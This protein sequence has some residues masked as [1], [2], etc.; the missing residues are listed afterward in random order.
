MTFPIR[1]IHTGLTL[2]DDGTFTYSGEIGDNPNVDPEKDVDLFK[3]DLGVGDRLRLPK[4]ID[5][6]DEND[7]NIGDA[8]LKMFD[9]SKLLELYD[10][11]D[12]NYI[13]YQANQ[14]GTFYVGISGDGN[15]NYNFEQE[16]SG[17]PGT[18]GKY[19][20]TIETIGRQIG[21]AKGKLY[22]SSGNTEDLYT[23]NRKTG[24]ATRLL[25]T[26]PNFQW[27]G[28]APSESSNFIYGGN[29]HLSKINADGS[30]AN[31]ISDDY[32]SNYDGLAYDSSKN[33]LYGTNG[34]DFYRINPNTGEP[35]SNLSSP[36]SSLHGL[37]FGNEGVYGLGSNKDLMFYNPNTDDW[38]VI[39]DT[40]ISEWNNV[41][42]AFDTEKNVLYAKR[43]GDTLLYEID[44]S[45]A[46]VTVLGDTGIEDGGGLA[47]INEDFYKE[48]NDT[49]QRATQTGLTK[50]N[51]GIFS[52]VGEIGD[53]TNILPQNDVDLFEIHLDLGERVRLPRVIQLI[54][55]EGEPIMNAEVQLFDATGNLHSLNSWPGSPGS[56]EYHS[57]IVTEEDQAG[58]FYVG[59]SGPG[60]TNYN[61]NIEGSGSG[62][63]YDE[64]RSYG[65]TI[66]TIGRE[67]GGTGTRKAQLYFSSD[68]EGFYTLNTTTGN[69]TPFSNDNYL[70]GNSGLAPSDSSGFLYGSNNYE[71]LKINTNGSVANPFSSYGGYEGL[72]YDDSRNILYGTNGYD[73]YSINPKTGEPISYLGSPGSLDG[74][75]FG[76]EGV[77]GLGSSADLMFYNPKTNYWSV[78]GYTGISEWNNVGLAFDTEQNVL[79]AKRDGDTLLYEIDASTGQ[80]Q[81]IGD[82]GIAD[83]GGLALVDHVSKGKLYFSSDYYGDGLYTLNTTTG[84]ATPV[85]INGN[86]MWMRGLAPSESSS[87]IYGSNESLFKINADG[88]VANQISNNP[89]YYNGLAYDS[90]RNILYGTDGYNL[91]T[92]NPNTGEPI[93]YLGSPGSLDGLAF[94]NEGV[95]GLG[96]SEDLMFY[97]PN[98]DDWSIIGK[99]GI[100]QWQ[101]VGL[102]FDT[103]KNVLYAKRDGDTLL[104][105]IDVSTAVVTVLG[106]TGIEYGGGLA[107]VNEDFYEEP[108]DTIARATQTGLTQKNHGI[109]SY[110]GEI[111]DNTNL[112]QPNDVDLFEI[113]LDLGEI[114]RLPT[115]IQLIGE[116]GEPIGA[117]E[118]QL[119]DATGGSYSL[120]PWPDSPDYQ[121]FIVTEEYQAGSFYVG[122]SGPGN[123]NYDP[124]IEGSG[125]GYEAGSYGLTIETIGRQ[126]GQIESERLFA[127]KDD[128]SNQIVELN[129]ETGEEINNFLAPETFSSES[130]GLAFDG[131]SLFFVENN[132]YSTKLWELNPDTGAVRDSD[133]ISDYGV[134]E[135]LAVLEGKV[136]ILDYGDGDILEFDPVIDEVTR[137]LDIDGINNFPVSLSRGL[138]GITGPNALL[139]INEYP[140]Q[141]LEI[142]PTTGLVTNSFSISNNSNGVAVVDNEIYIGNNSSA[143]IDVFDRFGTLLRTINN[144][145]ISALGGDDVV[146]IIFKEPNDTITRATHT[147]L[148]LTNPGTYTYS[149]KIG[150]NTNLLQQ[151]DVDLFKFDLDAGET[152]SLSS[153]VEI[154]DDDGNFVGNAEIRLFDSTGSH[155]SLSSYPDPN[156]LTYQALEIGT[157]YLGISGTGNT[158]YDPNIEGSGYGSIAGNYDL[159]IETTGSRI[160]DEPNDTL[161][162]A[163][164]TGLSLTNPGIYTFSGQVG[165]NSNILQEEDVDL[166]KFDLDIGEEVNFNLPELWVDNENPN[167]QATVRLFDS[168]GYE[169]SWDYWDYGPEPGGT[170]WTPEAGTFYLGISGDGNSYY[171]PNTEGSGSGSNFGSYE[172]T[173]ETIDRTMGDGEPNDTLT[174]ATDTGLSLTNPGIYTFSGQVGDNSNILQEED[175]DLFKFDL[176]IG[177]EVNFNLPELW[178]DN[179]N[180]NGQAT[181]RLFDSTGYEI[182]WDY[183][184]YGPEPGG[185]FWTPEAGTFYLGISGD[186]NSYY[187]PNTEGSGSGSNFGSYELTIETIDRTMGD[188][189]P[190]DTLTEATDTGLSLTNPGIY[191]FSGQ[192]GDNSN[193]LQEEDVDLF[194]FDLDIGEEVNFNLP[195]LWVD[196]E[197]PNGQATVRLFDSTGYEISWDY[198]DYGPEPGGTFWTPEAGT[199]YLGISGDGNSY[200]DPNTEGSGSGS[201]F[202]SYELTIETIDRTMGDG[203]PNDTLT[204]ATDTGLS[205]TNP[206]IYTFSGQ[207]GDNSNILQEEDVDLFK[208]DLDIG[209]EVNFNLPEL[210]DENN[211]PIGQATVRL[212]DS[213][214]IEI[215]WDYGTEAGT[216]TFLTPEPGTFYLGISGDGNISYDPNT[217]G[218]GSGSNFGSYELTIETIDRTMGDGEPND[219]LTEATDTGLSLTNPGIYTFSGQV[220]D[221]SNILQEED[222][223]LFKFDLDIG[224]EVNFNLPELLDENNSPI[225][226]ATVR[227]FDS[228][229]IEIDWDYGTEA[230]TG[231]F[232][233]PEPG[234][235]YLG[236]SGD[237]NISYDPN[238][239][240]SGS[241]SNFGSYEL[242]IETIDRTM[243]DGEPNDTLTEATDTGLSLTNPGIYTFSGQVGD[244]SNILQEEDVDLFK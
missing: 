191:T 216:G 7:N 96:P 59:I 142:N 78:I 50:K 226:Q 141:L 31:Q 188:G 230:G 125:Y 89:F 152:V 73:F 39:G 179:E 132:G 197:N 232:L 21:G 70:M 67:M 33:I 20:L 4:T 121:S 206:G 126:M 98:T 183:W 127:F 177:E 229:G 166:F 110:F 97:N 51:H 91:H 3:F 219:T 169:I 16:G 109:F 41:G 25:T 156:S 173:I 30:V 64:I 143:N 148:T 149:G 17:S 180:P 187:D 242:T 61:P 18:P 234:T 120:N 130:K 102:A 42:L 199:F 228:T 90:S 133:P 204:E 153:N 129:P 158:N 172:L 194:K 184:D 165:D 136:Y 10:P 85:T 55:E 235:F 203:E 167:G 195:E 241:G 56:P 92:I 162:E 99:T 95:Y 198:W 223:D 135:G 19:D 54:G 26:D 151:H 34:N 88:S 168:T 185:T 138:A 6:L 29:W 47:F 139:A 193:I 74:L 119:F 11:V 86:Q 101:N 24:N 146:S 227:L 116:E 171:D 57:F 240:G 159:T 14:A 202:G 81:S 147:G 108:N 163:T 117:A 1:A 178:V 155:I 83:G 72:A 80:I 103:E 244:N 211:S 66:E 63:G 82:T 134:F 243:G 32:P 150:D 238:T 87:F 104:Y 111:G 175:V 37:A 233:T 220:G 5:L 114:V 201:N 22:F 181:V 161:A 124:N 213:T 40:G 118:V 190:N 113:H 170:F 131:N 106:D 123:I 79:Y 182:S 49:I 100:Y 94:G 27:D 237:G 53:N 13:I 209:E 205:L 12:P 107:F 225:G 75:A 44:V 208:F 115:V 93:S 214:G 192:V 38:S 196:N 215:D 145:P 105:E 122:I 15:T 35:I 84:N 65:I 137:T 77:Y 207:V 48:S 68:N 43:D 45:T 210:L 186:G 52:Y 58:S 144:Y 140:E 112:L 2:R 36:F 217:E 164:D 76:N 62:H 9:N 160:G 221:N 200:Y 222:V 71:F 23:L 154:L 224:E 176:D 239:E 174:E 60:N 212:F 8:E 231:T 218:S 28:L 128:G 69:A 157:F 46:G 236:I 189:E